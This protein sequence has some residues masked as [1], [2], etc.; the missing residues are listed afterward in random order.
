MK[1]VALLTL[2]SSI[3][4]NAETIVSPDE[5]D[6]LSKGKTMYFSQDGEHYGTEQFFH[7]RSSKWRYSDGICENGEW[8]ADGDFIC[9]NYEHA[10]ETQCWHFIKTETGYIARPEG[11]PKDNFIDLDFID[12]KPLLCSSDGLSV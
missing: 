4:L 5:F 3:P 11:A 2:L 10:P 9:F 7:D 6:T 8:F 12:K 1:Y